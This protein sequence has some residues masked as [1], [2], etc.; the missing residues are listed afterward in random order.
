MEKTDL[1]KLKGLKIDGRMKHA[2]TLGRFG[3]AEAE[4]MSRPHDVCR[5][6]RLPQLQV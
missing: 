4:A 6:R 5:L 3:A 1:N 2:G